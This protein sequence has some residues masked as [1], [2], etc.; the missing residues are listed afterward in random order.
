VL[1]EEVR[2]IVR[3]RTQFEYAVRRRAPSL[4]DFLRYAQYEMNLD[5]LRK[6]RRSRLAFRR[7]QSTLM[8]DFVIARR[9]QDIFERAVRRFRGEL[10]LWLQFL[11]WNARTQNI[12]GFQRTLAQYVVVDALLIARPTVVYFC[13]DVQSS[14]IASHAAITLDQR[15]KL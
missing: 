7:T 4:V 2:S 13:C 3:K 8:T 12:K 5:S 10:S 1:Q 11:E 14:A 15:R 6:K 9:I